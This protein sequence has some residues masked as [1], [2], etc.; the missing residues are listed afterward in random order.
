MRV[1]K[2]INYAENQTWKDQDYPLY[3][4]TMGK[5]GHGKNTMERNTIISVA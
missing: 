1:W 5:R 3:Q 2:I 4:G